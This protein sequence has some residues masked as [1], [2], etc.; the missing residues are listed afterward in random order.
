MLRPVLIVPVLAV[1]AA[2]RTALD[3]ARPEQTI[4]WR[5]ALNM[6]AAA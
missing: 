3:D 6:P 5:R 4:E 1:A 2:A